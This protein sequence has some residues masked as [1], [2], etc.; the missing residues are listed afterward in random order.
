MGKVLKVNAWS[1]ASPQETPRHQRFY[2]IINCIV[3]M[4]CLVSVGGVMDSEVEF[5]V[6]LWEDLNV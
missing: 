4:V 1:T 2:R 3:Y 6:A 5:R